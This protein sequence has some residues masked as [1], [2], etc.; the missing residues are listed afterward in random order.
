MS[1]KATAWAFEQDPGS[2]VQKFILICL[3][4]CHNGHTGQCNPSFQ[5]LAD[6]TGYS[7]R[8][9]IRALADL[10]EGGFIE[11][12]RAFGRSSN[13]RLC[14]ERAGVTLSPVADVWGHETGAA[15]SDCLSPP[16]VTDSHPSSDTVS[17]PDQGGECQSVTTLVTE[18]HLTSDTVSPKPGR[19]REENREEDEETPDCVGRRVGVD[20]GDLVLQTA[21]GWIVTPTWRPPAEAV[22]RAKMAGVP[23][24]VIDD[25]GHLA[26][27]RLKYGEA[28]QRD[29]AFGKRWVSWM[30]NAHRNPD[31]HPT[32]AA[33]DA[34]GPITR[35]RQLAAEEERHGQ[36]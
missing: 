26:D 35:L 29:P 25:P 3:A 23:Q 33:F 5:R 21:S 9:V 36:S 1:H 14:L 15:G 32:A 20:G 6:V 24:D 27:F 28:P 18:C 7:R 22:A 30:L 34:V 17:P 2:P 12:I 31:R 8:T 11:P 4:D 10:T 16:L 13:Y 19:N